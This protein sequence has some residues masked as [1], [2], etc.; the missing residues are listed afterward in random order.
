MPHKDPEAKR[1]YNRAWAKAHPEI[2][3]NKT[4]RYRVRYP[5]AGKD[6]Y[7]QNKERI[8][9][10]YRE[11][12]AIKHGLALAKA[13]GMRS[14]FE[15]T[16]AQSLTKRKVKFGYETLKLPYTLSHFYKPDFILDNGIIIE[17]KGQFR[18]G[19]AEGSKMIAV[20]DQHPHL[21]IRFVFYNAH[22]KIGG[23]KQTYAQW[24]EK[25]GFIWAHEEIPDE[26]LK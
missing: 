26:W 16:L 22:A 24:A 20:R 4:R 11:R 7:E 17:A 15:R 5:N 19:K 23:Q 10:A 13:D 6:Y 3:R 1:A 12:Y 14:G 2:I 18:P 25:N 8:N 21:D 9:A